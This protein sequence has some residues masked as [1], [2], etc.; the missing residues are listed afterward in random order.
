MFD[1]EHLGDTCLESHMFAR[2]APLLLQSPSTGLSHLV[3]YDVEKALA[4]LVR[5]DN[6]EG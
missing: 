5:H 6:G 4:T 2:P 3:T 1:S